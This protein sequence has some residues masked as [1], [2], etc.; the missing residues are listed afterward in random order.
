ML[1]QVIMS[2]AG[3]SNLVLTLGLVFTRHPIDVSGLSC[4]WVRSY[5]L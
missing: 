3:L 1:Q 5:C 2:L 4:L